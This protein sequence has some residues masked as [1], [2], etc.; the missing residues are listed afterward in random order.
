MAASGQY[1]DFQWFY[2][3]IPTGA[4]KAAVHLDSIKHTSLEE[5]T[6]Q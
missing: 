6:W 2:E 5:V 4:Y 1:Y 3:R